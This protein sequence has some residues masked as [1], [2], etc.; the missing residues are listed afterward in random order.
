MN[1]HNGWKSE[2]TWTINVFYMEALEDMVKGGG[3][4]EDMKWYVENELR[5]GCLGNSATS[6]AVR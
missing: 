4:F 1:E 6:W 2:T 5:K 3:S